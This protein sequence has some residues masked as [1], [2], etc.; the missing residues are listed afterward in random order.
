MLSFYTCKRTTATDH[1]NQWCDS[2]VHMFLK[3]I[4]YPPLILNST[5]VLETGIVRIY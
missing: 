1:C 5:D 3:K 2:F 4:S